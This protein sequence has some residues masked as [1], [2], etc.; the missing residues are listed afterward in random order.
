[1][2]FIEKYRMLEIGK[3]FWNWNSFEIPPIW[4]RGG[5]KTREIFVLCTWDT[6]HAPHRNKTFYIYL[7]KLNS[8]YWITNGYK[9]RFMKNSIKILC[10][11]MSSHELNFHELN[12]KKN[13]TKYNLKLSQR[14]NITECLSFFLSFLFTLFLK[15]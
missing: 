5:Q 8:K 11:T 14:W 10:T 7:F 1:M 12:T 4:L 13:V 2:R 9:E 15:E 3:F 6:T